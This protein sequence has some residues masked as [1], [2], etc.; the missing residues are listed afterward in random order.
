MNSRLLILSTIVAGFLVALSIPARGLENGSSDFNFPWPALRAIPS[1]AAGLSYEQ[2]V[3]DFSRGRVPPGDWGRLRVFEERLKPFTGGC[4]GY[5]NVFLES[6]Y[7]A[8]LRWVI[9]NLGIFSDQDGTCAYVPKMEAGEERRAY[10]RDPFQPRPGSG[11]LAFLRRHKLAFTKY[12]D[13]CPETVCEERIDEMW[14]VVLFSRVPLP[15]VTEMLDYAKSF[16]PRRVVVLPVIVDAEGDESDAPASGANPGVGPSAEPPVIGVGPPPPETIPVP[17]GSLPPQDL[18]MPI[19]VIQ[20]QFPNIQ[21]AFNQ[22]VPMAHANAV[23]YL[24]YR[25][26]N[27]PLVWYLPHLAV[28]GIGKIGAAGDVLF[29]TAIPDHSVAAQLDFFTRRLGVHD[30]DT[31]SGSSRCQNVRGLMGYLTSVGLNNNVTLRHQGGEPSYGDG[32]LCDVAAFDL[33]G[34]VSTREGE[35]V[36]WQWIF[37][38]L[39]AGRSVVL[40]FSRYDNAGNWKSGHMLRVY[41]ASQFF[42]QRYIM[43]LDDGDQGNNYLGLQWTTFRVAD[44]GGP[45]DPG[46]PDGQLNLDATNWEVRFALSVDAHPKLVV[47]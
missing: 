40:S 39:L 16:R 14:T 27:P 35:N 31:G 25:Y 3:F 17:S 7:D 24:Q 43:T 22:C 30:L 41:G 29:W 20:E 32:A 47:P 23:K 45:G 44:T 42:G 34:L 11:L 36:T 21:A 2:V 15:A 37:D 4:A 33:G 8:E 19:Q 38:Q 9:E 10:R 5:L 18:V 6:G 26:H 1:D 12:F 13:L 46:N 28:R